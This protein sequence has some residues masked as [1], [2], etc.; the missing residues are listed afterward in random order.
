[1]FCWDAWSRGQGRR[2]S[3][4][5]QTNGESKSQVVTRYKQLDLPTFWSGINPDLVPHFG[6]NGR[7]DDVDIAYSRDI[8][9]QQLR[10]AEIA[11]H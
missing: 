2:L 1:M 8:V 9:R 3:N 6:Q 4:Q 7:I 10:Y 11:G 5:L